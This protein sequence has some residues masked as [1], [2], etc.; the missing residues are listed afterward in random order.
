MEKKAFFLIASINRNEALPYGKQKT[1]PKTVIRDH[2]QILAIRE[3]IHGSP[4]H[5]QIRITIA[6]HGLPN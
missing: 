1:G 6:N 4:Y 5:F 3:I 2:S